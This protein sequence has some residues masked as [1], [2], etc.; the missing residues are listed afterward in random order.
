MENEFINS[1]DKLIERDLNKLEVEI[2]LYRTEEAIWTIDQEIKNS[3]GNLCLHL[4][5]NLQY[6]FG[7]VLGNT[8]YV[9]NRDLEFSAKG[10]SREELMAQIQHA[11]G[12]VKST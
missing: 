6:Y 2:N 9:R 7:T 4:C 11:K 5:G 12:A 3:A 10:V 1:I 8:G